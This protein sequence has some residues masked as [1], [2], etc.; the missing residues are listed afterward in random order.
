MPNGMAQ[1]QR[2]DGRDDTTIIA[3]SGKPRLR[4]SGGA[5]VRLEPVLG[6]FLSFDSL[7]EFEVYIN[8]D[9]KWMPFLRFLILG[10]DSL[11]YFELRLF[12]C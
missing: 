7:L 11:V 6:A 5:A 12:E 4:A 3:H 8:A 2:R 9:D 10:C 1:R